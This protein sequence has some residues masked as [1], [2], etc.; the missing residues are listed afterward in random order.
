MVVIDA[1]GRRETWR[2]RF[3]WFFHARR[4]SS[5]ELRRIGREQLEPYDVSLVDGEVIEVTRDERSGHFWV[6]VRDGLVFEGEKLLLAT[7][8]RDGLPDV[9][10]FRE[11]WGKRVFVCPYCD[12]WKITCPKLPAS[13]LYG[14]ATTRLDFALGL[15][16][17]TRDVALVTAGD[18]MIESERERLHR[19]GVSLWEGPISRLEWEPTA[20]SITLVMRDEARLSRDA[21]FVH[22]G[23]DLAAPFARQLGCELNEQQTVRTHSGERSATP[24]LFVAGDASHDV[25][26]NRDRRG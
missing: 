14:P 6:R 8:M 2:Y 15:T 7:G 17:W 5:A 1:G 16:T 13:R 24:G 26:Q 22:F 3:S 10:G 11:L 19:N 9:P 20:S 4:G 23:E 21:V 18:A 12:G 25:Q